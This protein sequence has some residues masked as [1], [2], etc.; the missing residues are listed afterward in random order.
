MKSKLSQ[1][2]SMDLVFGFFIFI[3]A[4]SLFFY[5]LKGIPFL[6]RSPTINLQADFVFSNIET[7]PSTR[8]NFLEDYKVYEAKL[9]LF[10][11]IPYKKKDTDMDGLNDDNDFSTDADTD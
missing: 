3:I 7:I 6:S 4:I 10:S 11:G 5:T 8:I 1:I 9:E 2:I